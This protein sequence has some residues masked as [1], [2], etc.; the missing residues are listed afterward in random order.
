MGDGYMRIGP[1]LSLMLAFTPLAVGADDSY[2]PYAGEVFARGL[3]WGDTHVHSSWSVDAGN[4]GNLRLGPDSAFRF[5]RGEEVKAHN[6]MPVRLRRPLDFFLLSDHAE[7]LG[8]MP[9][10]DAADPLARATEGGERWYQYRKKGDM[11]A[12]F[13]EFAESFTAGADVV[14]NEALQKAVWSNVIDNAERFN[15]PGRFTAFIGYEWTSSAEGYNLHRNVIFRDGPDETSQVRPFSSLDSF[16]PEDL[17]RYL[18]DYEKKTGGRV[19]AIPHNSNLSGGRMFASETLNGAPLSQAYAEARQRWEP[20]LEVT[21]YKGDSETHPLLSPNDEFADYETWNG[22]IGGRPNDE[23]KLQYSYARSALKLGLRLE[24]RLGSNPFRFGLIG[25]SDSH[26]SL[27]AAEEDNFWGKF[28]RAE[29]SPERW[30]LPFF[31]EGAGRGVAY[32]EW[33]MAASGYAAVWARENTRE[34]IFDAMEHRETYATTG[35]R[36]VVRFFGGWCFTAGD[37]TRP[38]VAAVGYAGGV[39]MGGDLTPRAAAGCG[40]AASAPS[41]L[42]SVLKDPDGANLDRAQVVKGWLD[43]NGALA[44]RVYDVSVSGDRTIAADG[45]AREPVGTTVDIAA[46]RYTNSIG[47]VQLTG[48]WR[49]PDFDPAERAF[50][51]LRALEIPKP[52]WTAYDASYFGVALP[53]KVPMVTQD[54]AYTS[55]IWYTPGEPR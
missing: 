8:V 55:A 23:S 18:A 19:L 15:A 43:A 9:R 49:D 30:N 4:T 5:A 20:I 50:Y 38:D 26:T 46:A 31:N 24:A 39:P 48:V 27:A 40:E 29:P 22:T 44:E 2:S 7:Y 34:A 28:T 32:Y 13:A 6:G 53:E 12:I 35:P 10:L 42:V 25:S 17:W 14:D 36:M 3:Y 54:R 16:D 52:R 33:E 37:A 51:Y 47:S 1:W 41:F 11:D 45:R 21:Q